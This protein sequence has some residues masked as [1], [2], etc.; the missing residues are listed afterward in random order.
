MINTKSRMLL[1]GEDVACTYPFIVR[2]LIA[3]CKA[4]R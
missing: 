4:F 1:A 2:S 3:A